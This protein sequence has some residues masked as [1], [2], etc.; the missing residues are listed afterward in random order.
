[1][2]N[3]TVHDTNGDI[4]VL[5]IEE[6]PSGSL[7]EELTEQDFDVP[8]ICGGMAGC[9]TCHIQVLKGFEQLSEPDDDEAFMLE[10][11]P[12]YTETSRLSCQLN[13]TKALND[14]EVKVLGDGI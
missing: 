13:L 8:A 1:M 3:I 9:G 14:L 5:Q 10:S 11:L 4:R 7:M 2:I 12:N 6:N